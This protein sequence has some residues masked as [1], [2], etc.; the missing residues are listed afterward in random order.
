MIRY[1]DQAALRVRGVKSKLQRSHTCM[2]A[3]ALPYWD[4]TKP[5]RRRVN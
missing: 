1:P 3:V 5:P 4:V 2:I